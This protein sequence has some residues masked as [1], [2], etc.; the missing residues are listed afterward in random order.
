MKYFII[1]FF[2]ISFLLLASCKNNPATPETPGAVNA[3]PASPEEIKAVNEKILTDMIAGRI[4]GHKY[5]STYNE[6]N[7]FVKSMKESWSGMSQADQAHIKQIHERVIN[8]T[9]AYEAHR[10]YTDELDS[11]NV[12]LTAGR[13]SAAE[14]EKAYVTVKAQMQAEAQKIP[15]SKVDLGPLKAEFEGIFSAANKKAAG[16]Q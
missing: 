3:V 12:R 10:R 1:T 7:T 2:A 11:L 5:D 4:E 15:A 16:G 8:F 6:V 9:N 14:A 13:I